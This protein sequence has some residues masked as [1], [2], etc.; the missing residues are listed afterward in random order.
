MAIHRTNY[1]VPDPNVYGINS[2]TQPKAGTIIPL[3]LRSAAAYN[4][5]E[6]YN[7][8][9]KGVRLYVN[10]TTNSSNS[11]TVTVKVQVKD[12][13]SGTFVDMPGAT[14]AAIATVSETTLVIYPGASESTNIDIADPMSVSW[15]VVATVTSADCTF[16]VGGEYLI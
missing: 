10:I 13:V 15:R 3:A 7:P 2:A 5:P 4:S 16:S 8:W 11:G 14:T 6:L 1:P 9:A 12:P